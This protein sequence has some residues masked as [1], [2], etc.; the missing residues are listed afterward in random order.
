M[1]Q[2][3]EALDVTTIPYRDV[4]FFAPDVSVTRASGSETYVMRSEPLG[5]YGSR[6]GEW[7]ESWAQRAPT[8]RFIVE[9]RADGEAAVTYAQAYEQVTRLAEGLLGFELSAE[10]PL[11]ILASN[12]IEH[13]LVMLA[14]LHVGIAV[15]PIASAYALQATDY[16]K[17]AGCIEL[18]TPGLIVVEDGAA[19]RAA[20]AAAAA[21]I[22][23]VAIR[24]AQPGMRSLG[25]LYGDGSR[26]ADVRRAYE[27]VN[28]DTIAKFLFTSGSSG[29]PKAVINTH[30]MLCAAARQQQQ[31]APFFF[32][33]PPVMVDWL[34]WNHTA[35]GNSNFNIVLSNGGTM[36]IDPGKPTPELIGRSVE[37]LKRVSPTLYFNVPMGYDALLPYLQADEQLNAT[38]FRDMKYLWYAAAAMQPATWNALERL[39]VKAIGRRVLLLTGLGM[40]ETSPLA[41][42]GNKTACGPGVVGIPGPGLELKL[43]RHGDQFEARYRGP[44]VTPGYWRDPKNTAASF[45]DEGYFLSGDLLGFV[46]E[47]RP[48]LGLTF[49]GRVSEDFKV[50]SGTKV[51]AG[52]LRLNALFQFGPLVKDIVIAG[53]GRDDVRMLIFPDWSNAARAAGLDPATP[54]AQLLN[55]ARV[56]DIYHAKVREIAA[57]GTGSSNRIVAAIL[58]NVAPSAADGEITEKGTINGRR[59]LRNRPELLELLYEREDDPQVL[60][61]K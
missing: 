27:A 1:T 19:Y 51:A 32:D 11:V 21:D 13:A 17:L 10:R 4:P 54:S 31:I 5:P 3:S 37:L 40:T 7:L 48:E 33:E 9:Q 29:V 30:G 23:I 8:R 44:N 26:A 46:D 2:V 35:G 61:A 55:D 56:R 14:G 24:N 12:T 34:P 20:L 58:V 57:Q 60:R 42:F 41:L 45:D 6:M 18:L 38:F 28:R 36:Y 39:A 43:V 52:A 50:S 47:S 16:S 15:A 49:E 25:E 53:E 59:F 22:P